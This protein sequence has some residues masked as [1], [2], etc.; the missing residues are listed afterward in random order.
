[1]I[2]DQGQS[3]A[4][5]GRRVFAEWAYSAIS[6][7]K[8]QELEDEHED[9][10]WYDENLV[11]FLKWEGGVDFIAAL[12]SKMSMVEMDE[13]KGN[14]QFYEDLVVNRDLGRALH[15]IVA[16][17]AYCRKP[18]PGEYGTS[19]SKK[20][21]HTKTQAA[22]QQLTELINGQGLDIT[23]PNYGNARDEW[24]SPK[25]LQV[26]TFKPVKLTDILQSL[27]DEVEFIRFS[28]AFGGQAGF[29]HTE[30]FFVRKME[31]T[32]SGEVGCPVNDEVAAI[33]NYLFDTAGWSGKRVY[34]TC[35]GNRKKL[36]RDEGVNSYTERLFKRNTPQ[37]SVQVN[38]AQLNKLWRPPSS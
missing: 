10:D 20:Q 11:L 23:L 8:L 29:E 17:L 1:M 19:S 22:V 35:D 5:K 38:A 27:V 28:P 7:S 2:D 36:E 30:A 12:L 33:S 9:A 21:L 13:F 31:Q 14:L 4:V 15:T 18:M 34:N 24:G 25:Y 6:H 16:M 37:A 3:G 26:D 32:L